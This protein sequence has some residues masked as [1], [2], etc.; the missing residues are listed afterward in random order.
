MTRKPTNLLMLDKDDITQ[1]CGT[2]TSSE[3]RK[4]LNLSYTKY[5]I[6]LDYS[7]PFRDKYILIE[8][9]GDEKT[10]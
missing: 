9:L 3:V 8:D 6:F 7:K 10:M 5:V 1:V 4:E 2:I